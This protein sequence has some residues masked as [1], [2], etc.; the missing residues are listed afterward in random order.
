VPEFAE[1]VTTT[2]LAAIAAEL[3][4]S[5]TVTLYHDHVLVKEPGTRQRT[6][7]HQDQ[8]YYDVEG[9]QNVSFWI[10]V[11]PV[12]LQSTLEMIAGTHLGPWLIPRSFLDH[13][14]KWFPEGS[15]SEMGD[16]DAEL[17]EDPSSIRRWALEPGDAVAFHMLT[18]HG[19]PGVA[20]SDRRRVFSLRVLGDDMVHAPREWTTSPDFSA[21]IDSHEDE[22]VAGEALTGEWFP[23]LWPLDD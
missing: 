11:D 8:P 18:V 4:Q 16:I 2:K 3:M 12:P 14:A 22:R 15:L 20:G 17:G 13:Q 21:V 23:R 19:A 6:P 5:S 10:P 1:F 7:W 9:R